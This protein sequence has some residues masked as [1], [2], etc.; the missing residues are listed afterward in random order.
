MCRGHRD[1]SDC[2]W[3]RNSRIGCRGDRKEL[4][5]KLGMAGCGDDVAGQKTVA[6]DEQA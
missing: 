6:G 3:K 2:N 5:L 4:K 1:G